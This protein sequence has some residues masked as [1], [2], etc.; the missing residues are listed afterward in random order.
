MSL[1]LHDYKCH[2]CGIVEERRVHTEDGDKQEHCGMIMSQ[3]PS[4]PHLSY[5][6]MGN[7]PDMPTAWDKKGDW[8]T[9]R[10]KDAGQF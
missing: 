1:K 4:A 8:M 10:H 2:A 7:D 5:L 9:K 6:R 3:L